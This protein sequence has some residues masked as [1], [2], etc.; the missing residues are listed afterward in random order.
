MNR[1][2]RRLARF[3]KDP[4]SHPGREPTAAA[5]TPQDV[6]SAR[7]KSSGHGKRTAD[8]WNQ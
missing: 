1:Y 2:L 3:G 8:K 6:S 7:A 4:S 5:P